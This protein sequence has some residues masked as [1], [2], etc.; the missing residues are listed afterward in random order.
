MDQ[1]N[2][3]WKSNV[4]FIK[5]T[6]DSADKIL[7]LN[8]SGEMLE[9]FPNV[10]P[11]AKSNFPGITDS[12]VAKLLIP[13]NAQ[14]ERPLMMCHKCVDMTE[15]QLLVLLEG[16]TNF[17]DTPRFFSSLIMGSKSLGLETV[18]MPS[19]DKGAES[20]E[21]QAEVSGLPEVSS[22]KPAWPTWQNLSLLKI[23]K[24]A[25]Y[26]GGSLVIPATREAEAGESLEPGRWRLHILG[27]REGRSR[28]QEFK[29]SLANMEGQGVKLMSHH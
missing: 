9:G 27:S 13:G 15:E 29:T 3:L 14:M 26:S 17:W 22:L 23:Q 1:E 21:R 10:R 8:P 6:Y 25:G 20:I 11:V 28:C 12:W 18:Q 2:D 4:G 5:G 19:D 16:D 7:L 24:L